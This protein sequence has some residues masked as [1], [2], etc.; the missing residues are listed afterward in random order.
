MWCGG[1]HGECRLLGLPGGSP[2]PMRNGADIAD[3]WSQGTLVRCF[4]GPGALG[5][6]KAGRGGCHGMALQWNVLE[7]LHNRSQMG[8]GDDA[9]RRQAVTGDV[10]H[11]QCNE[12][13]PWVARGLWCRARVVG[14]MVWVDQNP[15]HARE[16]SVR[17]RAVRKSKTGQ[18]KANMHRGMIGLVCDSVR[19][20]LCIEVLT[21][22]QPLGYGPCSGRKYATCDPERREKKLR[23]GIE[24]DTT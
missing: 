12:Y 6:S 20:R 4:T 8:A 14:V 13:S 24:P 22:Q 11:V 10:K 18:T 17:T 3:K 21:A 5:S 2:L 1:G 9:G 19:V 23:A 16:G 15:H 7:G